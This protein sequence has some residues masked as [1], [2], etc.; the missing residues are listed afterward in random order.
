MKRFTVLIL[1]LILSVALISIL[2]L[3]NMRQSIPVILQSDY[4]L[5]NNI[6]DQDTPEDIEDITDILAQAKIYKPFLD[7][8]EKIPEYSAVYADLKTAIE[9]AY[10]LYQLYQLFENQPIPVNNITEAIQKFNAAAENFK[11]I[12]LESENDKKT[13]ESNLIAKFYIGGVKCAYDEKSKTF[14]YTMGQTGN[15]KLIFDFYAESALESNLFAEIY[16]L[17]GNQTEYKFVPELNKEYKIKFYSK[18]VMAEYKIIFTM[19]PIIQINNINRI[20]DHYRDC[21]ISITDPDFSYGQ[22]FYTNMTSHLFVETTA[23]IHIRGGISSGFPKKSYAVKFVGEYGENKNLSFFG[24]RSDS[25]WILD[26]MYI[27][28]ARARNRISTDVWNDYNSQLY[29][30]Q[31]EM[32]PQSNGTH[33][34]FV[35]VFVGKE[36]MGLYCFTE[37]I[38]RKQL[39]LLKNT[40][41]DGTAQSVIY[42]GISWEEPILFYRYPKP[43]NKKYWGGFEQKYPLPISSKNIFWDPLEEFVDFA[44]NS[45]DKNF[46]A[47]ID[48]YIDVANFADYTLLMF[49]TYAIDNTGK[50]CYWSVYNVNIKDMSKF[51]ITPWDLDATWGR[52]WEGSKLKYSELYSWT[53]RR[54]NSDSNLFRRLLF[55]NAGGFTDQVKQRWNELKNNILSPEKLFERFDTVFDLFD[56]SGAWNRESKKW[57]ESDLDLEYERKYIKK[58]IFDRWDYIDKYISNYL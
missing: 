5:L 25:D 13:H 44:V 27:D 56:Q 33:G 43:S 1:I 17:K 42:K 39:Q 15:Q 22:E 6:P 26:A 37:K 19:L 58:W 46:K 24:M 14:F 30:I 2:I 32:K 21:M 31:D 36:Y 28:K 54:S 3:L 20:S 35:E 18:N 8:A 9:N 7:D 47:N 40:D 57:R 55:T 53:N 52:S 29:Y 41:P 48:Q 38:D 4:H 23:K 51:F 50:N 45:S 12:Y 10:Q 49:M 16:D 11:M 34:I